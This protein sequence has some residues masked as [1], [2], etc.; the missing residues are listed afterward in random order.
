MGCLSG[1]GGHGLGVG[2]LFSRRVVWGRDMARGGLGGV[3][4]RKGYDGV[5]FN[6]ITYGKYM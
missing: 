4:N 6:Y 3:G 1:E 2:T 5:G